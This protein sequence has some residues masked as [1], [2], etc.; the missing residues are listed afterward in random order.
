MPDTKFI[1]V[2]QGGG[3]YVYSYT[4]SEDYDFLICSINGYGHNRRGFSDVSFWLKNGSYTKL[5]WD[6]WNGDVNNPGYTGIFLLFNITKGDRCS[7][8]SEDGSTFFK[9][10]S[11]L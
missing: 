5:N 8:Y 7:V 3:L 11:I 6:N 1:C 2:E 4:F 9:C 10:F